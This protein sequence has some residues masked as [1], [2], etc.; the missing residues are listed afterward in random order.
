MGDMV[1]FSRN[2]WLPLLLCLGL[3]G[4]SGDAPDGSR[5][6]LGI[7][8][9]PYA[10]GTVMRV[11]TDHNTHDSPAGTF[12]DLAATSIPSGAAQATIAAAADGWIRVIEDDNNATGPGTW[13]NFVWIEHPYPYCQNDPSKNDWPNKPADYDQTCIP[14]DEG[15]FCNEWTVY[16][17]M[18][19]NSVSGTHAEGDWVVS[20]EGIGL[21]DDVGQADGVH[22]HWHVAIIDPSAVSSARDENGYYDDWTDGAWHS[23]PELFPDMCRTTPD[24]FAMHAGDTFTAMPC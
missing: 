2:G 18:S 1:P 23:S 4:C 12:Y 21:E 16:A 14:C 7:Y 17:H 13:N 10:T 19:E 3:G 8:R 5:Y 6:A 15:S 9:I 24:I 22:L 11:S 20:G